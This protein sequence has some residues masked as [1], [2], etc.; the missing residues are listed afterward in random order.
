MML[1]G[2]NV[3]PLMVLLLSWEL[4]VGRVGECLSAKWKSRVGWEEI[5]VWL[6]EGNPHL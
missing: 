3:I 1:M 6:R 5:I 4:L 2:Q